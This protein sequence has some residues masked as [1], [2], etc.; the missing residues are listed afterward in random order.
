MCRSPTR[1]RFA[2]WQTAV[3]ARQPS[4]RVVG[5]VA[6]GAPAYHV[7]WRQG[8]VVETA[9][10]DPVADGLAVRRPLA[11]NVTAIRALVD[12]ICL[13]S[14][15]EMLTAATLAWQRAHIMAEPSGVAGLAAWM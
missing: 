15:G 5:A 14:D 13:V 9:S 11:A 12:D 7:S 2:A 1:L 3:K 10:A 6:T 4:A 8:R